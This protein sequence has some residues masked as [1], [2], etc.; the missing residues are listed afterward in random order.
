MTLEG[1]VIIRIFKRKETIQFSGRQHTRSGI[2]SAV[3]GIFVVLGFITI[4]II[5][6]I[7]GG[8]G[9]IL[10]GI[11]GILLFALSLFGFILSYKSLKE[12]DIYYRF[13]MTGMI[14]NGI[15]LIVLMI[16]YMLGL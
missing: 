5:S 11:A 8:E 2:L 15:M 6:G 3:V 13:P 1:G 16:L 14:A 4:S 12:R 9:G 7:H 10:I